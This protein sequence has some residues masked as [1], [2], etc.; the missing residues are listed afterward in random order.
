MSVKKKKTSRAEPSPIG[1]VRSLLPGLAA[2]GASSLLTS[3][4]AAVIA[5]ATSDPG[6]YVFPAGLTALYLSA[7]V[8]GFVARKR[9]G[10]LSLLTGA[11]C[12]IAQVAVTL[13]LSLLVPDAASSGLSPTAIFCTRLPIVG[14]SVLGA[15]LASAER[16]K[17]HHRRKR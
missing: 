14:L 9:S 11:L 15:Y 2:F 7:C 1:S 3:I 8:G 16:K 17:K 13:L 4:A 5:Y 10:G 6:K 12:G